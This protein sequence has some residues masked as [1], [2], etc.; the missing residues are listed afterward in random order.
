MFVAAMSS[1]VN[2]QALASPTSKFFS[3]SGLLISPK[4]GEMEDGGMRRWRDGEM[5]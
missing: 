5:R 2:T 4:S 3:T 1:M